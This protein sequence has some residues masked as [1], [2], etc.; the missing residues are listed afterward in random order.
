M[1]NADSQPSNASDQPFP[2]LKCVWGGWLC[3]LASSS[4]FYASV[5]GV[6]ADSD[7]LSALLMMA[8]RMFGLGAFVAGGIAI[9]NRWWM[10]GTLLFAGSV[11]L[12]MI[13]LFVYGYL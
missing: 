1:D 2:A 12:P 3:L 11:V 6:G 8:A 9:F 5:H 7:T 4:I 10:H 13:S